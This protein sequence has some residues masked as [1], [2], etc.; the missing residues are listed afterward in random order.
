MQAHFL[1]QRKGKMRWKGTRKKWQNTNVGFSGALAFTPAYILE[2]RFAETQ[3]YHFSL[4]YLGAS[5]EFD[6][7]KIRF[8]QHCL[9]LFHQKSLKSKSHMHTVS[10]RK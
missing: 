5:G 4:N 9:A 6:L 7:R 10:R 2:N 3:L 8:Y 1:L